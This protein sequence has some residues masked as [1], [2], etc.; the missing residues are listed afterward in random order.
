MEVV[1]KGVY[2]DASNVSEL[3]VSGVVLYVRQSNSTGIVRAVSEFR[4][5]A[6]VKEL[7]MGTTA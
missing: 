2:F 5:P 3:Y 1:W 7:C 4:R 6:E